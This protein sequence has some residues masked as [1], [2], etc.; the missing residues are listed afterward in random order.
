MEQE[1]GSE[2]R[3]ESQDSPI[4][5]GDDIQLYDNQISP[6]PGEGGRPEIN[7]NPSSSSSSAWCVTR[8]LLLCGYQGGAI[9]AA[10]A[11]SSTIILCQVPGCLRRDFLSSRHNF[12][13]TAVQHLAT[14]GQNLSHVQELQAQIPLPDSVPSDCISILQP[15]PRSPLSRSRPPIFLFPA[16]L[17]SE[18]PTPPPPPAGHKIVSGCIF[19]VGS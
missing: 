5:S 6:G 15:P 12:H 11:W 14:R 2:S 3:E 17:G 19:S 1:E 9:S 7:Y 4:A 18:T 16:K 8:W 10:L 13:V